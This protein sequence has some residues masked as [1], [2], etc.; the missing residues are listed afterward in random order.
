MRTSSALPQVSLFWHQQT[1]T[2]VSMFILRNMHRFFHLA[3]THCTPSH[4]TLH[5]PLL[6]NTEPTRKE[7][8]QPND[9]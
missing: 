7:M 2:V 9:L 8:R 3:L 4:C 5:V 6:F 1:N